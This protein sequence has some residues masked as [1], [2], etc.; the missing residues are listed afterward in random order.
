MT[1]GERSP[2][3]ERVCALAERRLSTEEV[4]AALAVPLGPDEEEETR[5]LIRWFRTRYATPAERLAY[6]RRAYRRWT[7]RAGFASL[8]GDREAEPSG[9][10]DSFRNE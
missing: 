7:N 1:E 10:S 9:E 2:A 6:V 4:E 8:R 5:A 3:L